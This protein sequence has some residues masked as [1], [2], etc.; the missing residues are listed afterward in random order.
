MPPSAQGP[1]LVVIATHDDVITVGTSS[2]LKKF[3]VKTK[4]AL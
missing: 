3:V 1:K 4:G 2:S